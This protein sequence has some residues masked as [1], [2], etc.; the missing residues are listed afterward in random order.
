MNEGEEQGALIITGIITRPGWLF[1][2]AAAPGHRRTRPSSFTRSL[3]SVGHRHRPS[4][5]CHCHRR[6]RKQWLVTR[7]PPRLHLRYITLSRSIFCSHLPTTAPT[8][9]AIPTAFQLVSSTFTSANIIS[10]SY[11]TTNHTP[12][13]HPH[14]L[15]HAP[16][17][18]G[19]YGCKRTS[20]MDTLCCKGRHRKGNSS[21]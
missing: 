12:L 8:L 6:R 19:R 4:A 14:H 10:P 9:I 11:F 20:K 7:S 3:Q 13:R 2:F 21:P 17:L 16:H 1:V 5:H 18:L 15:T